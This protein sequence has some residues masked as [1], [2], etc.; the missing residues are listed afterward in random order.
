MN[1]IQNDIEFSQ[2]VSSGT[3]LVTHVFSKRCYVQYLDRSTRPLVVTVCSHGR[4]VVVL[5]T[6][7][8]VGE[9][10]A[11]TPGDPPP[12]FDLGDTEDCKSKLPNQNVIHS[13]TVDPGK[14]LLFFLLLTKMR[15]KSATYGSKSNK[16][17]KSRYHENNIMTMVSRSVVGVPRRMQTLP[18]TK[19]KYFVPKHVGCRSKGV[20]TTKKSLVETKLTT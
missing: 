14:P 2:C 6:P 4:R 9:R 11:L 17:K 7:G 3:P 19:F 10:A 13:L 12:L 15:T 8:T 18:D 1:G 5:G 16:N 20:K